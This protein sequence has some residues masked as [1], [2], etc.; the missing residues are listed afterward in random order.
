MKYFLIANAMISI[1]RCDQPSQWRTSRTLS[2]KAPN[3]LS[4]EMKCWSN[5]IEIF[6]G[7]VEYMYSGAHTITD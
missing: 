5:T 1:A 6:S 2:A 7:R 4:F 3:S